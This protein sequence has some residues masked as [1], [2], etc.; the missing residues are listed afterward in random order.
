MQVFS[1]MALLISY[2]QGNYG[3]AFGFPCRCAHAINRHFAEQYF[4][5][6]T[7]STN[8]FPQTP[9]RGDTFF[10]IVDGLLST[11]RSTLAYVVEAV[12]Y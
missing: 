12:K 7:R 3:E 1:R 9:Q 6:L 5:Q 11:V 2:Q 8:S 4:F 10:P